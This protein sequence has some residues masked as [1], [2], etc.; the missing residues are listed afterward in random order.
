MPTVQDRPLVVTILPMAGVELHPN[1]MGTR[2]ASAPARRYVAGVALIVSLAFAE[3]APSQSTS[4][5][6]ATTAEAPTSEI[7]LDGVNAR[8]KAVENAQDLDP[9]TAEK[10]LELLRASAAQLELAREFTARTEVFRKGIEEG[11]L[12]LE[13]LKESARIGGADASCGE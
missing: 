3:Q 7:D 9:A 1:T 6:P 5:D 12:E 13:E 8:I 4:T 10:S 11:P 2:T